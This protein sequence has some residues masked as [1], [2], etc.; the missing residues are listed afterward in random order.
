MNFKEAWEILELP[1]GTDQGAIKKKYRELTKKF[2]PDVNKSPDA[3]DKFKKI[4]EAYKI[5]T[6]GKNTE[7]RSQYI[8]TNIEL[9]VEITFKES[10]LG[11]KKNFSYNRTIL[12]NSCEGNGAKPKNNGCDRCHGKGVVVSKN[13]NMIFTQTCPKCMGKVEVE[14]CVACHGDGTVNTNTTI[15]VTTPGGILDG[16]ILRLGGRGNFVGAFMGMGQFT[17]V[18]V[19]V[20]VIPMEGLSIRNNDVI[21]YLP[22]S[23]IEALTGCTKE[24]NT[25]N[26]SNTINVPPLSKNKDEI[27]IPNLGVSGMGNHVT[28]LQVSYP[29]DTDNLIKFLKKED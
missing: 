23:L 26:G 8:P 15:L 17:D 25:I 1:E 29:E 27:A 20:K 12:C 19:H 28:I 21:S 2:H 22:L 16:S 18:F 4:N 9:N 24:I 10:V 6:T 14:Q 5:V 7:P 3:E 11:L 13:A